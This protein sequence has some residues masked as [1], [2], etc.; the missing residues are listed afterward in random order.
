MAGLTDYTSQNV[1]N[2][3]TGR[4]AMPALPSVWLALFTTAPTSDAAVTGATEVSGTGYARVQVAGSVAATAA[5]TTSS[6]NITMTTNPGWVVSGMSVYD[7]TNGQ[8]IGTVSTYVGTAL[9]LT[10]NASHASS[11]SS[12]SLTF[13][14]FA[15]P[16]AS[17]GSEP[18][19][20]P[21]NSTNT[22]A[23][24]TFAQAGSGGWGTVLAWGLFDAATSGN[25]LWWDWLGNNKWSPFT[26]TSASPG[27]LTCTDQA[28]VNGGFAVV[29]AKFG[30]TLP[31]TGGSWAG[32]LT[33]AGVS[34]STFNLGVNTTGTG[35]GL[36]RNITEQ[37]I[38]ANVTASFSTS[39]M[40]VSLA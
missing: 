32:P 17:S 33:I 36:V 29:S 2:Y 3:L 18:A 13:S 6:P 30:G 26:C 27:V 23:T 31:T 15:A 8:A 14:A 21:A 37:S 19:V 10:A 39:A 24:I 34:G 1:L 16:S 5:F 9:V 12:D 25:N 4:I 11:G 40:T 38:P 28:F 35:D 7:T 22:N 20:T